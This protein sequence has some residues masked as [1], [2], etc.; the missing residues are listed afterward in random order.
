MADAGWSDDDTEAY[1]RL[2]PYVVPERERQVAI[3]VDLVRAVPARGDV[4]D[5]G[6]GAGPLTAALLAALPDVRVHAFDG[7]AAMLERAR[8]AAPAGERL[9]TAQV[10]LAARG[11]RS[12]DEPLRAVVSSLAIHHLDTAN[13]RA[14]FADLYRLLAPGGVFVLADILRPTRSVG[15]AVAGTMWDEET[16]RRA[17]AIDG[18]DRG[19]RA[20]QQARW[21]CFQTAEVDPVDKPS[22]LR[23]QLGWLEDGGFVDVDVHWLLAG[24]V[25][26]SAWKP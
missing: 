3:V 26:L 20:F 14:L 13:K 10:D 1:L 16:R 9:R 21:N 8:T 12:F 17:L 25:L 15:Q 2:A 23:E 24:Q 19:F 5:L 22:S 7:S 18:D 11:W 6:C 4:L